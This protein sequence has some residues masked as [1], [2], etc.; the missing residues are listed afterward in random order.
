MF[1]SA[2]SGRLVAACALAVCTVGT[3]AA[4]T[5][6]PHMVWAK[7]GYQIDVTALN[8]Q[9]Q[10][11]GKITDLA[12]DK[13]PARAVYLDGNS[14]ADLHVIPENDANQLT[15]A[16]GLNNAGQL[17][18]YVVNVPLSKRQ[19][20]LWLRGQRLALGTLEQQFVATAINDAGQIVGKGYPTKYASYAHAMMWSNGVLTDLDPGALRSSSAIDINASG[21]ILLKGAGYPLIWEQGQYRQLAFAPGVL[22]APTP[23]AIN[24]R[25]EVVGRANVDNTSWTLWFAAWWPTPETLINLGSLYDKGGSA[26]DINNAGLIVGASYRYD[27]VA[28]NIKPYATIWEPADRTPRLLLDL[29]PTLKA[30]GWTLTLARLVNQRGYIVVDGINPAVGKRTF[31]LEPAP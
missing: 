23:L 30:A 20:V 22:A 3:Q 10:L 25:A 14:A 19:D 16:T 6:I 4:T 21:Q 27:T 8:D 7:P 31:L 28:Q 11:A 2:S 12:N 24:D 13:L 18:G 29:C 1:I 26:L 9:N 15:A 17:L 5:Y